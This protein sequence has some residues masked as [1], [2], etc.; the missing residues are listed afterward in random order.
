MWKSY[1]CFHFF[2]FPKDKQ[3]VHS[4][5]DCS[6][7]LDTAIESYWETVVL[8]KHWQFLSFVIKFT[9]LSGITATSKERDKKKQSLGC[10][11]GFL[12][13]LRTFCFRPL[14]WALLLFLMY[15]SVLL[16]IYIYIISQLN[17]GC[18]SRFWIKKTKDTWS[19]RSWRSTWHRKVTQRLFVFTK[20]SLCGCVSVHLSFLLPSHSQLWRPVWCVECRRALHPGGDGRDADGT[21]WPR[22]ELH[23]LQRCHQPADYWP[24]HVDS[25]FVWQPNCWH[26][27]QTKVCLWFWYGIINTSAGSTLTLN[28]SDQIVFNWTDRFG[29]MQ[30]GAQLF[31][32]QPRAASY[33]S[34]FYPNSICIFPSMTWQHAL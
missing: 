17:H 19:Q 2:C 23:L 29:T 22:E 7:N 34:T 15:S 30:P 3:H 33:I 12:P 24:R 32:V 25:A 21:R 13:F 10:V 26:I 16:N 27:L 28:F 9:L 11:S 20:I 31:L 6:N 1:F 8:T 18:A 14:R 5:T 4:C